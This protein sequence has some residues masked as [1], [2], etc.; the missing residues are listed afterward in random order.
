MIQKS[1]IHHITAVAG[2]PQQNLDFYAGLLGLRLVKKTVNFDDPSVYHLYYGDETGRPGSI[3]TFFPWEKL[4]Q[5][6]PDR[7]QAIAISFSIPPGS[8]AFWTE[9]LESNG[10][11]FIEPFTRFGKEIIG[12]QDPDGLHLELV[13]DK[14]AS[15]ADG[16]DGGPVPGEH[17]IRGIHGVALALDDFKPTGELLTESLGF[18]E[19]EREHDRVLYQSDSQFGSTVEIIDGAELDG[20]SGKGTVHHVAFRAEDDEEHM[21]MRDELV[22]K[23]YHVT[24]VKDRQYFQSIYFHEPGG[25]L[26]EVATD[27]PGFDI[28][29]PVDSLGKE[30]KLPPWLEERRDLIEADLTTLKF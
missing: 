18:R 7:G 13:A 5:G 3:L 23:G 1:G 26:F 16:W 11:D 25:V 15:D 17:A 4:Q 9:Y 6:H 14:V 24:E 19:I 2:D 20:R 10:V 12:L 27:S 8:A 28:D 22:K 29:E 30:L 21:E